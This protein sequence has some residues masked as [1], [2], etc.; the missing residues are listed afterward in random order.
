MMKVQAAS[1]PTRT[2]NNS[3]S[4][5]NIAKPGCRDRCGNVSIPY[6]FGM[7]SGNCYLNIGFKIYCNSSYNPPVA[8]LISG[9]A[10][11]LYEILELTQ[12]YV[13]INISAPAICDLD[14]TTSITSKLIDPLTNST[15]PNFF[16]T[17]F[18][19]S[20]TLN[21]FTVLGCNIFGV[22][23]PLQVSIF[24]DGSNFTSIGCATRCA[25]NES[26]ATPSPCLGNGCCKVSIPDRLS[27]FIIK[28]EKISSG[29]RVIVPF[30]SKGPCVHAFI[31]EQEYKVDDIILSKDT[32]V[33]VILDWAITDGFLTCQQAQSNLSMYACGRNTD[34]I[35]S[36]NSPGYRCK[37]LKGYGGNA[38]LPGGCQDI[39]EC[40]ELNKCGKG[41]NC[42]NTPGGYN[43]V[44]SPGKLLVTDELG[45][46][47][48]PYK[49]NLLIA[50]AVP[51]GMY[52]IS[53]SW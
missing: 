51:L 17:P 53:L 43:C 5:G 42:L 11:R 46:Q 22:I 31:V 8:F 50:V 23:S 40:E 28:I 24:G 26:I 38:Y 27:N 6:P 39:D 9:H 49:R 16:G 21:K 2:I 52:A 33:P 37:C 12:D 41:V 10:V 29:A 34:C 25:S 18:T 35:E 20:N 4:T 1:A 3:T 30:S 45:L 19:I 7:D 32:S 15:A 44:C 47:C 13:R 48:M 14:N 36:Y